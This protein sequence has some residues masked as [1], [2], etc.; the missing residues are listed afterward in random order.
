[1]DLDRVRSPAVADYDAFADPDVRGRR[2]ARTTRAVGIAAVVVAAAFGAAAGMHSGAAG[3]AGAKAPG[4]A[5]LSGV[6]AATGAAA[7]SAPVAAVPGD[8]ARLAELAREGRR[9]MANVA[10]A[11]IAVGAGL[12]PTATTHVHDA[13][14]LA[15]RLVADG[16]AF[17]A[18]HPAQI[19][20]LARDA[21]PGTAAWLPLQDDE[22]IVRTLDATLAARD[23][24]PVAPAEAHAV[25]TRRKVDARRVLAHLE[26]ADAALGRADYGAAADEL[27]AAEAAIVAETDVRDLPLERVHDDLALARRLA[28]D[29]N[30]GSAADAVGFARAALADAELATPG[31]RDR[32]DVVALRAEIAG[33]ESRVGPREPAG[34]QRL[35]ATMHRWLAA[36]P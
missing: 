33:L 19:A 18:A 17:G 12:Y 24:A 11:R 23:A 26:R 28:A 2:P 10:I 21:R 27:V 7:A 1:M 15:E 14:P 9:L 32:P 8:A 16:A 29:R 31:L 22:R 6:P 5:G 4:S 34:L 3:A 30:Y 35:E 20:K 36:T 13:L 25:R